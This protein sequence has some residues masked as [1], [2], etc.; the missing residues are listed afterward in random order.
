L[1]RRLSLMF[2]IPAIKT[3]VIPNVVRYLQK[4]GVVTQ[5]RIEDSISTF[6][7]LRR[8]RGSG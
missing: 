5:A 1:V 2:A 4:R 6:E 7:I 3:P 8:L